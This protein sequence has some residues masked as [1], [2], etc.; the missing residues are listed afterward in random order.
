MNSA[1]T[2]RL[3]PWNSPSSTSRTSWSELL[4]NIA[5]LAILYEDLRLE[6]RELQAIHREVMTLGGKDS[7]NRAPYFLRR[8]LETLVEFGRGLA[9]PED[10]PQFCLE[11][12][13]SQ[14][15]MSLRSLAATC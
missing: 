13:W 5:R 1:G 10:A 12:D 7:E 14:V 9:A 2:F 11:C 3:K 4:N 8:A 6:I 15:G